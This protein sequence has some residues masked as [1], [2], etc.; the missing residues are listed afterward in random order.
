MSK[1]IEEILVPRPEARLR[2][3]AWTPNDRPAEYV[4]LIKVGQTTRRCEARVQSS[5]KVRCIRRTRSTLDALAER[6]DGTIF[7]R[8]RGPAALV[9][10]GFENVMMARPRWMRCS[11]DD[12]KTVLTELRTDCRLH[13]HA[14]RDLRHASRAGEAVNRTHAYFDSIWEEDADAVPRFLWNAKM[15]FGKTFAAYQLAK[16]L[17]AKRV[18]VVTFK[19]AVADAWQTDLESHVDFDGWQFTS[20]DDRQRP[21]RS[22]LRSRSSTS[23]RS[24]IC[25]AGTRPA[26]SSPERVAS[27][28]QLGSRDL[29][30]VP[31]R[32]VA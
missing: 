13:G 4:G 28:R 3:Y 20:R 1:P 10:K 31:L 6:D 24:R 18:L 5:L 29:R 19:P 8:P 22:T 25:S 15:R 32:R 7:T 16:K 11:V 14:S 9:R 26:T 17:G 21:R 12:V 27:C 30:R 23:A 2:I